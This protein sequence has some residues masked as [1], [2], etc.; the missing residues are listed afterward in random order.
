[1]YCLGCRAPR[2]PAGGMV[3]DVSDA[4]G[5]AMLQGLCPVCLKVMNVRVA[6]RRIAEFREAAKRRST[7]TDDTTVTNGTGV[8]GNPTLSLPSSITLTGKTIT[9]GTFTPEGLSVTSSSAFQP[10]VFVRNETA[11]TS[12]PYFMVRK[13][14]GSSGAGS[15]VQVGD[16]LGTFMF[17]GA[18]SN[19]TIQNGANL[20]A[21]VA[22]V[23]AGTVTA[24]FE[25]TAGSSVAQF[26]TAGYFNV[27]GHF[28]VASTQ[29]VSTRK[30]G[31]DAPTGTATRT[32]F[33]TSTVTT[34]QLA[35]RV[36][37]LVDDLTTHGLIGA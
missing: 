34:A 6:R 5:A 18:D 9:G 7:G 36:K 27:P 25:L 15:A 29:V 1:M 22:S 24:H 35:E 30:T 33:V 10:Q 26:N 3:D 4:R 31:W 23:S 12:G 11:G 2:I 20:N 32:T 16:T 17:Q 8:S 21:L 28:R 13:A 37:A 14:R 19:G